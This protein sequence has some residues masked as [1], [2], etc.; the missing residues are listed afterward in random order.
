MEQFRKWSTGSSYPAI[1]DEDVAKTLIPLPD[2]KIQD[3]IAKTLRAAAIER[4]ASI[5]AAN[6]AWKGVVDGVM[7]GLS[8]SKPIPAARKAPNGIYSIEQIRN[9]L[10]SLA[11]VEEEAISTEEE[12]FDEEDEANE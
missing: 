4:E 5:K 7:A 9:R 10:A 6:V 1:L 3:Q 11:A 12:L 2:P 8:D